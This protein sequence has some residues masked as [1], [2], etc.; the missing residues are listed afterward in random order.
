MKMKL[1]KGMV[2][3]VS[4]FLI[5]LALAVGL[6][7]CG[8]TPEYDAPLPYALSI[9]STTGGYVTATVDRNQTVVGPGETRIILDIPAGTDVDLVASPD[10]GCE[11]V[12]WVGVPIYGVTDP[13]TT[14]DMQDNYEITARFEE[15]PATYELNMAASPLGGGTA[16]DETNAG[17]Y[18]EGNSVAIRAQ[19]SESYRFVNWTAPAGV[20]GNANEE[21]TTFAMPAENIIVTAN[22]ELIPLVPTYEVIMAVSPL[23]SGTATDETNANPYE[24]GTSI[25]IVAEASQ[26]FRF[27]SWTAPAGSFGN[28]NEEGTTFTVP[29]EEATVI[30]N[31][32]AIPTYELAMAVSPVGCG[33]ATDETNSGPYQE[34]A[35]VNIKAAANQGY[36]FVNWT[37]PAGA[38]DNADEAETTFTM[39]GEAVTVT[40]NFEVEPMV[41]G[42]GYHTVGLNS[43]GTVVAVG[44]NT[45]RQCDVGSW[46]NIIQAAAGYKHT[47]GVKSDGTVVA[48]GD[49][50]YGQCNLGAWTDII[51]VAAGYR[52][53]VGLKSDGT[54]VA[55]GDNSHGQCG[56]GDWTDIVQVA[57]G[58]RHTVGLKSDGTV[59]AVGD[60]Y[61][62][63]CDVDGWSGISQVTAGGYHT[64]A[65]ESD[66]T[67][68]AVGWNDFGQCSV[69]G[70]ADIAQA[71]AGYY[72][73]AALESDGTVVATGLNNNGQ[74][75]VG[76]W[77][78][79][80]QVT[81]GYYHT[82][83]LKSD[84]SVVAVGLNTDGQCDVVTWNLS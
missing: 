27:V 43:D 68:V 84:G 13:V 32:E 57:A 73:T 1:G 19:A 20:F 7:G 46:E 76:D 35:R 61:F 6:T 25:N 72:H 26:G 53:T 51:K 66:G 5:V 10:E 40:A 23:G 21:E 79:I 74:C 15:I 56:V 49:N 80:V 62:G 3:T 54:V 28:A 50:S 59:V 44:L 18:E 38:F 45:D 17:P 42:G 58:Y 41:A 37:A 16:S 47:V 64:A 63:Q 52:H 8:S 29:G 33:R 60:N 31:F 75:N 36:H 22:F 14:I 9:H 12:R 83:G 70:W 67:A 11:F 4:I 71:A 69:D 34:G 82:V 65:L 30:A 77:V 55:V 48:V 39:P 2:G 81:A 24:E 78:D